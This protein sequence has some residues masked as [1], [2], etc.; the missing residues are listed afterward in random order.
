[1][2]LGLIGKLKRGLA[3]TTGAIASGLGRAVG[4]GRGRERE[5]LDVFEEVLVSADVGI[6]TALRLREELETR[7]R[8]GEVRARDPA[9]LIAP[10]RDELKRLM[11]RRASAPVWAPEPPTVVLVVGVNGTGKT[12]S[13]GKLA[14]Y[15]GETGKRKVVLAAADTFRA[16]A[17]EQLSIW[18][19]RAG[20]EIVKHG[21]GADPA[22]VVHDAAEAAVARKADVLL[23][24]TAGRLHTR[25]NLMREL[26]KIRRVAS[27]KVEG[28]PHEV[29]LVLDATTGQNAVSQAKRFAD[30]VGL[31]GLFLAK[32]DGTA[33]GGVVVAIWNEIRVPVKYVGVGEGIDDILPFYP[34]EFVDALFPADLVEGPS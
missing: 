7:L 11:P 30:V 9:A 2:A 28:A 10:V 23:V 3:R 13:V 21:H 32:L 27:R 29:L 31:T 17:T 19:E 5:A 20:V 33:K 12:T 22:A 26:E 15:L 25:E 16:A 18:A 1:M 24:D 8:R 34:E 4:L 14:R 6:Q